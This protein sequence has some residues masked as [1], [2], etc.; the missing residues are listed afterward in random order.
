MVW[1]LVLIALIAVFGLGT[2]LEAAFW[3][4]VLIALAVVL[5]GF[6]ASR[7]IAGSGGPARRTGVRGS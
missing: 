4:L 3:A 6:A 7:A 2:V 1:L 5:I